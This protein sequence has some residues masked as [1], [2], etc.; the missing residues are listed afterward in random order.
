[1]LKIWGRIS[2]IDVRKVVFTAQMLHLPFE[3]IDAGAAFGI[4]KTP[5]YLARNPNALVPTLE[6]GDFV[7]FVLA[8]RWFKALSM[9]C[10][11]SR[12]CTGGSWRRG[13]SPLRGCMIEPMRVPGPRGGCSPPSAR[14]ARRTKLRGAALD[15]PFASA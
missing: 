14:I 2:S 11:C 3:R 9:T 15:R 5:E 8:E 1:M 13:T 4:T 10:P 6:D 12:R 7:L